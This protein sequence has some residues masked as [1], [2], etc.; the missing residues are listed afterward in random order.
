[1]NDFNIIDKE[2]ITIPVDWLEDIS[3]VDTPG[4]ISRV[5]NNKVKA[6]MQ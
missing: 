5:F 4:F 2:R 6:Q 3:L 1:M